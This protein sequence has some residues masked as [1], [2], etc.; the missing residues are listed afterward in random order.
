MSVLSLKIGF[1]SIFF[2]PFF[3][4]R[5]FGAFSAAN[6]S[7]LASMHNFIPS[8]RKGVATRAKLLTNM[9]SVS[10]WRLR[11]KNAKDVV[12]RLRDLGSKASVRDVARELGWSKPTVMKFLSLGLIDRCRRRRRASAGRRLELDVNSVIWLVNACQRGRIPRPTEIRPF[13]RIRTRIERIGTDG[14]FSELP[15]RPSVAEV[16]KFLGCGE[17]TVLRMLRNQVIRARRKPV[18]RWDIWKKSLPVWCR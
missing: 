17:T 8:L 3:S 6:L 7:Q 9:R 15:T 11:N 12:Q 4:H 13:N 5:A 10:A 1:A 14:S 18:C 2:Q 16:A